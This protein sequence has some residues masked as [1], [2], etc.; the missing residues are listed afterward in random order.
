MQLLPEFGNLYSLTRLGMFN[1]F[2]VKDGS[3][4]T[5]IDTNLP[6][7]CKAILRAAASLRFPITKIAL[8]HAHFDHVGSLNDLAKA[9]P[10]AEISMSGREARFL[11]GDFSL[12]PGEKGKPLFGFKRS[13]AH[14]HKFLD[15]GDQVGSLRVITCPGHS[16]GHIAFLDVRDNS[17]IAGDS[18]I[19][20]KGVIAAGVYSFFFPMPAWFS[21]NAGLAAISAAKLSA[22]KPSRLAVGHGPTIVSP[23]A[24]MD[25]AVQVAFQQ[26]P[27]RK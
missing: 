23:S 8:T 6:G 13:E 17:L 22:L 10:D 9:L 16:P 2:L 27:I 19:T 15:D 14:V 4:L 3:E 5:L 12:D 21:W 7:S 24:E 26:H 20:Q 1:C 25:L 18:F 11:R